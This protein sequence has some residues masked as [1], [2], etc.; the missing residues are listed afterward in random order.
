M[1]YPIPQITVTAPPPSETQWPMHDRV[2]WVANLVL[3]L[4][5][6][7]GIWVA[8]STLK[9]IER[10]MKSVEEA[11]A[12]VAVTSQAS[13][14][15][16]EAIRRSER[17]WIT[18][19]AEPSA[20]ADNSSIVVATNR[21]RGPARIVGIVDRITSAM[22]EAHLPAHPE[23]GPE[24]DR[25]VSAPMILLPGE[26]MA[27]RKFGP[28][29][30]KH[31]CSEETLRRIQEWSEKIFIYGRVTYKDLNADESQQLHETSWCCW[32][33]YGQRKSGLVTTGVPA[34][35]KVR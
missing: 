31:A 28:E 34:F 1:N 21:G 32:Y 19:T 8:L 7:A 12:A 4:V 20:D 9:K 13:L 10:Q 3:A 26:S 35:T 18:I 25:V 15:Q 23:Y 6:Y 22:D 33:I 27:L 2:S 11:I 29:D 14:Q 16:A 5:G 17:P 30:V 24:P